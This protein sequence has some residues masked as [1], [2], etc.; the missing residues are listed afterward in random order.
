MNLR[1]FTLGELAESRSAYP[2][3]GAYLFVERNG[4][5]SEFH[6]ITL[7]RARELFNYI[8]AFSPG[9][10]GYIIRPVKVVKL[11]YA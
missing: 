10:L 1:E 9:V 4:K 6:C 3:W 5:R 8:E 2:L 11:S 7:E